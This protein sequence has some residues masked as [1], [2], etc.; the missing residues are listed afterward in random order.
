MTTTLPL[1]P[2]IASPANEEAGLGCLRTSRGN[3]PLTAVDVAARITGLVAEVVLRTTF[4]NATNEAL[5]AVYV[6][7]LPDRS[8]V[9]GFRM[10]VGDRVV[11]GL[12]RERGQAREDYA[13]ALDEGRRAAL[14]EE[15]RPGVFTVSV[16]NLA[17]GDVASVRLVLVGPLT[18]DAGPNGQERGAMQATFRFP[19]VVAPRYV[20]GVPLPGPS[21]GGGTALDTDVVPDASRVTPPVLLPGFPNPVVL[22]ITA[23]VDPA[24]LAVGDLWSSLPATVDEGLV[25]VDPGQRANCDF[26]LRFGI[27]A[28]SV[29]TGLAVSGGAFALT[30]VPPTAEG[31]RPRDV[32]LVL[33]RSGS[34]GGW[35]MVAARRAAARMVD[36]LGR[37]DRVLVLAFDDQVE[38]SAGLVPAIDRNRFRAVELLAGLEARGG[39]EMAAPLAEA[40]DAFAGGTEGRDAVLVL[41]TDGQVADEDHLLATVSHRLGATRIF[42][43]GI[44]TA[45]NAGFLRRLAA[46]GG[47]SCELV[48][49]EDRLDEVL[50]RLHRRIATPAVRDLRLE[51][52]GLTLEAGTVSP[53]RLPDLFPGAPLVVTGH[54][55]ATSGSLRL[56]GM[57]AGGAAWSVVVPAVPVRRRRWR[58]RGLGAISATSRTATPWH[59]RPSWSSASWRP[60]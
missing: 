23:I 34:M 48:E 31:E 4:V 49:S 11:E 28:S 8:A 58:R 32:V 5:E 9:T 39:T 51:D 3:L 15:D 41:V 17:P 44:D 14:A 54:C 40:L 30:V 53:A 57:L 43:V 38:R 20:P 25:R 35:K 13:A 33:D 22:S 19:L 52:D 10:E 16:G 46:L 1:L 60:R 26:V 21:V 7:P 47:G 37:A 27:G 29:T 36:S 55:G 56:T 59:L 24:G 12:L 18:V 2:P 6:L 42:T 50:T 45:V